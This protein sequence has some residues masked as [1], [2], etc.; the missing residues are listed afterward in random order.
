MGISGVAG[1]RVEPAVDVAQLG[2]CSRRASR[3][4]PRSLAGPDLGLAHGAGACR[5]ILSDLGVAPTGTRGFAASSTR[6]DSAIVGRAPG[7]RARVGSATGGSA[8]RR[9]CSRAGP[10]RL[11]NRAIVESSGGSGMGCG[12][13]GSRPSCRT[14]VGRLGCTASFGP[15]LAADRRAFL[16]QP[17]R[18]VVGH[19]Q[20]RRTRRTAGAILGCAA[21]A[22]SGLGH[23]IRTGAAAAQA[24]G[25][26]SASAVERGSGAGVV[27]AWRR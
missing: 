4:G 11:P 19:P 20:D 2:C 18:G 22:A 14:G 27:S 1:R 16:G 21:R 8:C 15:R 7:A 3:S 25:R 13:A 26:S 24:A 6:V 10:A 23:A 5:R 12:S 17:G 9:A